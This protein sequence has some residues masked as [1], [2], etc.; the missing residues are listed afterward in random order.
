MWTGLTEADVEW[1]A[2]LVERVTRPRVPAAQLLGRQAERARIQ[3]A[4]PGWLVWVDV[5]GIWSATRRPN[6]AEQVEADSPADL[7]AALARAE[8]AGQQTRQQ[9]QR[10]PEGGADQRGARSTLTRRVPGATL[11]RRGAPAEPIDAAVLSRVM[12]GIRKL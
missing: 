1:L 11:R 3:A 10:A 2:G 12:E 7:R 8:G 5:H 4:H 9:A 6:A